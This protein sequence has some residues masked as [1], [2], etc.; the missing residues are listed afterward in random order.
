MCS[1]FDV[2]TGFLYSF[3][4]LGVQIHKKKCWVLKLFTCQS[5]CFL[6]WFNFDV[7]VLFWVKLRLDPWDLWSSIS[8]LLFLILSSLNFWVFEK[9]MQWGEFD[10]FMMHKEKCVCDD[11]W[12]LIMIAVIIVLLCSLCCVWMWSW[13]YLGLLLTY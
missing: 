13:G 9:C 12:V 8:T 7:H 1:W 6:D 11:Y 10:D 5:F 4:V 3:L 2:K